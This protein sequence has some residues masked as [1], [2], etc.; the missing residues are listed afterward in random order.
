[1][2]H[3]HDV[4]KHGAHW[5]TQWWHGAAILFLG[6]AMLCSSGWWTR[7]RRPT[8]DCVVISLVIVG[9]T[10][11]VLMQTGRYLSYPPTWPTRSPLWFWSVRPRRIRP[12][13]FVICLALA[14]AAGVRLYSLSVA[15]WGELLAFR[16]LTG[17]AAFAIALLLFAILRVCSCIAKDYGLRGLLPSFDY[18]DEYGHHW[19]NEET[20]LRIVF[21]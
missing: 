19:E 21:F 9:G 3:L 8:W 4:R 15:A 12:F 6:L 13:N 1:M 18:A 16:P 17:A 20:F 10:V 14:V 11:C 7:E 5:W 2:F